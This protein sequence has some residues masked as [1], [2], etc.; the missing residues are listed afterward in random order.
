MR[1]HRLV[2]LVPLLLAALAH[3]QPRF[4]R[5]GVPLPEGSLARLGSAGF[6]HMGRDSGPASAVFSPDGHYLVT[7]ASDSAMM[8][9]TRTCRRCGTVTASK[10]AAIHFAAFSPDGQA[11]DIAFGGS[12]GRVPLN[13]QN[14]SV[15]LDEPKVSE[16]HAVVWFDYLPG[17]KN[18]VF[19]EKRG[20]LGVREAGGKVIRRV[21]HGA[22][23]PL[24]AL[25]RDGKTLVIWNQDRVDR[26]DVEKLTKIGSVKFPYL[27]QFHRLRL[28]PD[29]ALMA[30]HLGE[31]LILYWDPVSGKEVSLLKDASLVMHMGMEFTPDGKQVATVSPT[32]GAD[33]VVQLWDVAT[34][35]LERRFAI[36]VR[37]TGN[38]VVSRD[39]R[40]MSFNAARTAVSLWD[41]P[42]VKTLYDRRGTDEVPIALAVANDGR[43]VA[44]GGQQL[45]VW[46][47]AATNL[48]KSVRRPFEC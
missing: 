4:D 34:N 20:D 22:A 40:L 7:L 21:P 14:F 6:R 35:K 32:G 23:Q 25:S 36:P 24:A 33:A 29:G 3:A 12:I 28:R 30:I 17:G 26:W 44:A 11:L 18:L 9:D 31:G 37:E 43:L 8:W 13:G 47:T 38:P 48:L 46:D 1:I 19:V 39:G 5:E 16:E 45:F 41:V 2:A 15:H 27:G 42:T 10:D